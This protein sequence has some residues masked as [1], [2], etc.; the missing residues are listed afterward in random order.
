MATPSQYL[1]TAAGYIGI[2]GTDNI[3]NTWIWGHP[4]YDPYQYP[5]CAAYQSY[6]GVHDLDMPFS[7][8]ASAA[9][10][11]WQGER[12]PDSEARAGDWVL[13]NWDGRQ[14][15][16]W[17]DHIGVVEWSDINGSGY[18]GTIEG[19]TG[20]SYGGEVARCTRYNDGG[21]ATAFFRP[22]YGEDKPIMPEQFPGSTVNDAGLA[23]RVHCQNAGW[24]PAVRDGQ[25]AGSVGYG[26]RME[27]IKIRPPKG[28]KLEVAA[29]IATI[30]WRRYIV[31]GD[32]PS[33]GEGTSDGDLIIGTVGQSLAIEAIG[34]RVLQRPSDD[35]RTLYFRVHKQNFGWM[36]F[37][38]EG[39]FSGSDGES[40]RLEAIQMKLQ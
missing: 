7:P 1:D 37:T 14:D 21:Y 5:W 40:L 32:A 17:A 13:F 15:F 20:S 18:F 6:V 19:N 38:P 39:F 26:A 35:K 22:P 3:F 31:D 25:T 29:H 10:V 28:Y 24:F 16:G 8:S 34:V 12:V 2:S 30:G 9:G 36:A 33:S 4:C 27:A 23:Y 11:G